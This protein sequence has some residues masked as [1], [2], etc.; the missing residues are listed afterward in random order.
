MVVDLST[1]ELVSIGVLLALSAGGAAVAQ[2]VFRRLEHQ[3]HAE[4]E[5]L[6][7]PNL[8]RSSSGRPLDLM[9]FVLSRRFA[10]LNDRR[11][12]VLVTLSVAITLGIL[13]QMMFIAFW[14]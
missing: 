2:M 12:T 4:W 9:R 7:R 5:R 10:K 11:L 8:L 1:L 6:G 14:L 3:H 13:G